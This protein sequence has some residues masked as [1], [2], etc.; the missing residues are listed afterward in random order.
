MPLMHEIEDEVV[1]LIAA[2]FGTDADVAPLP[3]RVSEYDRVIDTPQ[4]WVAISATSGG[5]EKSASCLY[6]EEMVTLEI[7]LKSAKLRGTLGIYDLADRTR[8]AVLGKRP[9][10]GS[11][12][13]KFKQYQHNG[14]KDGIFDC[15][16]FV[17]FPSVILVENYDTSTG[18]G[19]LLQEVR[20]SQIPV[21]S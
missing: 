21:P 14:E 2:E 9:V 17:E 6:Q 8:K 11:G 3:E 5:P 13:I 15:S 20:L 12:W 16:L 18:D 7:M 10:T 4:V 1:S 19:A